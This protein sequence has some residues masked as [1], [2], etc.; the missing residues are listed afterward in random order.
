MGGELF[1]DVYSY[2]IHHRS[3]DKTDEG[4]LF[5][6]LKEMVHNDKR[7]LTEVFKLDGIVFREI[8][9]ENQGNLKR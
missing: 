9:L 2:L 4:Q 3:L 7:M 5:D 1:D 6:D 8:V